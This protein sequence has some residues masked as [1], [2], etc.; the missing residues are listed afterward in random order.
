MV[1][2]LHLKELLGRLKNLF[3]GLLKSVQG[4]VLKVYSE[5]V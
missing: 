2:I 1:K 5:L 3:E 4:L